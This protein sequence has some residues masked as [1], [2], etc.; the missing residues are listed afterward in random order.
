MMKLVAATAA[1]TMLAACTFGNAAPGAASVQSPSVRR[2]D[3]P[4]V[5]G[6]QIFPSNNPWNADIS[7]YP[8]DPNSDAYI[9]ALPGNLHPDF[10]HD[11]HYGIPFVVVPKNQKKVPVHFGY[12]SQSDPGPYPIPFPTRRSKAGRTRKA[13]A[14]CSYCN[15]TPASYTKCGEPFPKTTAKNG[16]PA[17]GRSFR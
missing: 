12:A 3:V 8:L 17:P 10:G 11:P 15:K 5:G 14:T 7:Q 4:V 13:T 9:G 2:A 1:C 16:A 6:C